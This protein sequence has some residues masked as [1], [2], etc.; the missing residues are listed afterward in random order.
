MEVEERLGHLLTQQLLQE[1]YKV[2][3]QLLARFQAQ[4]VVVEEEELQVDQQKLCQVVM[5]DLEV[6]LEVEGTYR[7]EQVTHHQ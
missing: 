4:V 2:Q 5:A 3:L 1:A 7:V 6:D